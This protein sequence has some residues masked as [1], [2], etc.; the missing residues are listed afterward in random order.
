MAEQPRTRAPARF[1]T[2]VD[3]LTDGL[4]RLVRQHFELA[5]TEVRREATELGVHLRA[6]AV[7]ATI[8]IV[9]Y[10]LLNFSIIAVALWLGDIAAMAITSLVLA[11]VHLGV[12]TFASLR[13]VRKLGDSDVGLSETTEELQRDK[14]WIKEIRDNSPEKLPRQTS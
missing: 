11:F 5:R 14:Q 9:G 12:G 7:F 2:I 10:I 1:E 3:E 13:V 6:L 8:A 4:S